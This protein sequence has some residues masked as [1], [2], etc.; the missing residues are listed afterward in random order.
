MEVTTWPPLCPLPAQELSITS[1]ATPARK[2][3]L[4]LIRSLA[5]KQPKYLLLLFIQQAYIH[6]F[7]S[8]YLAYWPANQRESWLIYKHE[9]SCIFYLQ[10][11]QLQNE[12][13][14]AN[15]SQPKEE[16]APAADAKEAPAAEEDNLWSEF[17]GREVRC[18]QEKKYP[19]YFSDDVL[20]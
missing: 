16:A 7:V 4:K 13:A 15:L 17:Q 3:Y 10:D 14:W 1:S 20:L 2:R 12:G 6:D 19:V 18:Q 11:I 9:H 5:D 8:V